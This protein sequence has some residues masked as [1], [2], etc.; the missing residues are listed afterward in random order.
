MIA[1]FW[2]DL[3]FDAASTAR[4]SSG[5]GSFTIE[6]R[7]VF[8]YET[9]DRVDFEITLYDDGQ[10]LIEYRNLAPGEHARGWGAR[11]P[12]GSRTQPARSGSSTRSTKR[13]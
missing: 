2:D 4:T 3:V 1:G 11:P 6:Y 13:S 8:F 12:S 10:I 5:S 9:V 7:N